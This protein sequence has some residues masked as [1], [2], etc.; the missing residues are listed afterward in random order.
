MELGE[1]NGSE[2]KPPRDL[3]RRRNGTDAHTNTTELIVT[4]PPAIAVN[5]AFSAAQIYATIMGLG[6]MIAALATAGYLFIPAKDKDLQELKV[7]V[8]LIRNDQIQ[9]RQSNKELALAINELSKTVAE[10]KGQRV[11]FPAGTR[12][13]ERR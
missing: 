2:T 11:M 10:I 13:T 1:M 6:G 8:E 4:S 5:F 7:I 3:R 9:N 12:R